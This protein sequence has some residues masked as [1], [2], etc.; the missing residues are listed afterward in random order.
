MKITVKVTAEQ[1]RAVIAQAWGCD[2]SDV[3]DMVEV[4]V[5]VVTTLKGAQ[6]AEKIIDKATKATSE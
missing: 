1:I 3:A 2:I 6:K 5:D 4:E